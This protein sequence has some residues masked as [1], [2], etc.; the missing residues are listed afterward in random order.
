M[1]WGGDPSILGL[2]FPSNAMESR[3]PHPPRRG[4]R[5]LGERT[6]GANGWRLTEVGGWGAREGSGLTSILSPPSVSSSAILR[7]TNACSSRPPATGER[8][9]VASQTRRRRHFYDGPWSQVCR[10]TRSCFRSASRKQAPDL[11]GA[12]FHP[13][14]FCP[15]FLPG[16][17]PREDLTVVSLALSGRR[18]EM[19]KPGDLVLLSVEEDKLDT[20]PLWNMENNVKRRNT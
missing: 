14:V 13:L 18:R 7:E 20:T 3:A 1:A 12:G 6:K 11:P 17:A 10:S 19:T 15:G 16:W 2:P 8:K 9:P 4:G 5:L